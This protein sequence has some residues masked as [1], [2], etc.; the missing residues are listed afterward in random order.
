MIGPGEKKALNAILGMCPLQSKENEMTHGIKNKL[1]EQDDFV[2]VSSEGISAK[3]SSLTAPLMP[4]L[5]MSREACSTLFDTPWRSNASPVVLTRQAAI[6]LL[7]A[8]ENDLECQRS[9]ISFCASSL[10]SCFHLTAGEVI[11]WTYTFLFLMATLLGASSVSSAL[12]LGSLVYR[13]YLVGCARSFFA[14]IYETA[15][16]LQDGPLSRAKAL[17]RSKAK[18]FVLSMVASALLPKDVLAAHMT[19]CVLFGFMEKALKCLFRLSIPSVIFLRSIKEMGNAYAS[20]LVEAV[21]VNL[22][23]TSRPKALPPPPPPEG[24]NDA[25]LPTLEGVEAAV[26]DA[27]SQGV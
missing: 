5:L 27:S 22:R 3:W 7:N 23:G 8:F 11:G 25:D 12:G 2:D 4:S 26:T 13:I 19:A 24:S 9:W 17:V 18:T 15:C 16:I 10:Q 14:F 6:Y 20:R 21:F 1:S